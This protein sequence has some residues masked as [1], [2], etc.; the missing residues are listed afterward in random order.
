M[1]IPGYA[2][3]D[4]GGTQL[5]FGLTDDQGQLLFKDKAPTPPS[6]EGLMRLIGELWQNLKNR[7]AESVKAIGFGFA[8][9]YSTKERRVLHSPN[10][11]ALDNFE[12]FPALSSI[13]DVP[14]TVD[15]DANMAAFG[16]WKSGA[17]KGAQSLV[18][19]TL[20]TGVGGGVV[21]EGELWQ[22]KCGF[23]GEVGH[24]TVNP[25]GRT[26][27]CGIRGCLETESSATAIVRNYQELRKSREQITAEEV[28]HRAKAGDREARASF[29]R[30]SSYLGIGLGIIINFLNPELI[31]LGGGVMN[32][33]DLILPAAAEEARKRSNQVSFAC[34]SIERASLGNDA[35]LIGAALWAKERA[36][37]K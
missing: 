5:K 34:C 29:A 28:Y 31:L 3:F 17:G 13:L 16:E 18:L 19:L 22:G 20:G 35:G 6:I 23:A 4:L 11:P 21:L 14:Y 26:C 24:I 25:Q 32:P 1:K 30:A 7:K 15:N 2:G 27:N 8:G 37:I 10:Y 36:R 9:F 33:G 12:L